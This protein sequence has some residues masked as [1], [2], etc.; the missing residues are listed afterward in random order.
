[1]ADHLEV[2]WDLDTEARRRAGEL[3]L[4]F[5]RAATAGSDPRFAQLVVDLMQGVEHG[6]PST[7]G[8]VDGTP[9]VPGCCTARATAGAPE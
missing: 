3:G 7:G 4:G 2:V 5:A 1:V 9:C 8:E 6:V